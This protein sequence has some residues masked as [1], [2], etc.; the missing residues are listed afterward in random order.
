MQRLRGAQPSSAAHRD[1]ERPG[2]RGSDS[3]RLPAQPGARVKPARLFGRGGESTVTQVLAPA[4]ARNRHFEAVTN[5]SPLPPLLV[6]GTAAAAA[7]RIQAVG[8]AHGAPSTDTPSRV[9]TES[10]VPRANSVKLTGTETVRSSPARPKTLSERTCT[11][12]PRN[13]A[14]GT[15]RWKPLPRPGPNQRISDH[16]HRRGIRT[17]MVRVRVVTPVPRHSSHGFSMSEPLP[18][19]SVHGSEN[20]NAP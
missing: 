20:P 9:G 1:Q 15:A 6:L 13:P 12:T 16:Y 4:S 14:S 17:L 18:R 11:V 2:V 3:R 8:G 7:R 10:V 19:H 5:R